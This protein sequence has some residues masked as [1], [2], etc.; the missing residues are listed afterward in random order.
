MEEL[1]S[2]LKQTDF[3]RTV[4]IEVGLDFKQPPHCRRDVQVAQ[5]RQARGEFIRHFTAVKARF[6]ASRVTSWKIDCDLV[7]EMDAEMEARMTVKKALPVLGEG[8][9]N[10]GD[11][12]E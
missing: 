9:S 8:T 12:D 10:S 7:D 5:S 6:D 4:P 2:V 3:V 11:K 1:A